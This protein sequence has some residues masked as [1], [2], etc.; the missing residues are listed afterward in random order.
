MGSKAG[1]PQEGASGGRPYLLALLRSPQAGIAAAIRNLRL[2]KP[3][4]KDRTQWLLLEGAICRQTYGT[5]SLRCQVGWV[6]DGCLFP[7]ALL[8]QLEDPA[9][10]VRPPVQLPEVRGFQGFSVQEDWPAL[11]F[12]I[13]LGHLLWW[14][15]STPMPLLRSNKA[16]WLGTRSL[17]H[18]AFAYCEVNV[19]ILFAVQTAA[20]QHATTPRIPVFLPCKLLP[21][22][23]IA[24][25]L[26]LQTS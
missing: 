22:C 23:S 6:F 5:L 12:E 24:D 20:S 3:C 7:C 21:N 18:F 17:N 25:K 8:A 13:A 2:P 10:R 15:R 1:C 14:A 9:S 4:S 19:T 11:R 26:W 16:A